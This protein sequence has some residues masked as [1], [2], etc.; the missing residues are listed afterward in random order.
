MDLLS[1]IL[2]TGVVLFVVVLLIKELF[3]ESAASLLA[4][5][6]EKPFKPVS[7]RLIGAVGKVVDNTESDDGLI[8]V[9]IGI[10]RWNARLNSADGRP[11]P[12][13]AEVRVTAVNGLVLDVEENTA[14]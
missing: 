10:E 6:P 4:S 3:G 14:G 1:G 2:L 5:H 8:K 11:L 7:E 9:R 12:V 13:G